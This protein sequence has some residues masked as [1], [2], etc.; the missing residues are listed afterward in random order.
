MFGAS[1]G[2]PTITAENPVCAAVPTARTVQ[3]YLGRTRYRRRLRRLVC[4]GSR[5]FESLFDLGQRGLV[6]LELAGRQPLV[7][8]GGAPAAHDR[9]G[10]AR[11]GERPRDG[12][13]ADPHAQP[14]R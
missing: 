11:D 12:E 6:E 2:T 14:V 7:H 9:A 8:L 5:L 4:P 10:D 13:G 3:R 1:T